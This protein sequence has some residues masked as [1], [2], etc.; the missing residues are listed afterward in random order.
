MAVSETAKL[1]LPVTTVLNAM[2]SFLVPLFHTSSQVSPENA[3]WYAAYTRSRH[4][5]KVAGQLVERDIQFFLPLLRARHRWHD[6]RKDVELP[7]F[8]GY[9]FVYLPLEAKLRVLQ[10]PGVVTFV[11]FA[12]IPAPI[13]D[14][15]INWLQ[16]VSSTRASAE[17]YPYFH[18]GARV[19]IR[20]GPLAGIEGLVQREKGRMRFVIS[21]TLIMRSVAL[22]LDAMDLEPL[23]S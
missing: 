7:V 10:V 13:P 15:E 20:S 2:S 23:G 1:H 19:R 21:V 11:S 9:L 4:E 14:T 22:E 8:P 12:G 5:K 17:A 3:R 6:R 16:R 18:T